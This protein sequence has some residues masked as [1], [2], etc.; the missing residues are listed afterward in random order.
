MLAPFAKI[1]KVLLTGDDLVIA[2]GFT[3]TGNVGYTN[4]II[5]LFGALGMTSADLAVPANATEDTL[6][7][8]DEK[9]VV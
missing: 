6:K 2:D 5:P 8:I 1:I 3:L 9:E 4:A 7:S